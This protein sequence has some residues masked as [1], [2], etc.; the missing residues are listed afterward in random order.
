MALFRHLLITR[1][2]VPNPAW[3]QDKSGADVRTPAWLDHRFSLFERYCLPSVRNQRGAEFRWC[4]FFDEA[5]PPPY[6]ERI[7]RD[8]G[9]DLFEPVYV[10]DYD[11]LRPA[12]RERAD[13]E[14]LITTRLDND[15][16]LQRNALA[17]VQSCFEE[18]PAEIIN[19][20][21]G[22]FLHEDRIYVADDPANPFL[23][24]IEQRGGEP[25][26]T[27]WFGAHQEGAA[28]APTRQVNG[29]A[30]WL[31]VVHER[32]FG[33]RA[34]IHPGAWPRRLARAVLVLAGLRDRNAAAPRE[35][36]TPLSLEDIHDEFGIV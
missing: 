26:R 36:L 9:N 8:R 10:P 15:D 24:L 3:Q 30:R 21:R 29:A 31:R 19:L 25:F 16:A 11:A 5:T 4:I 6:R 1:F 14:F 35:R 23:S 34:P 28:F 2:N 17:T 13:R 22:Y 7:E 32:N 18:Q 12:I 20:T 27:A 33:S